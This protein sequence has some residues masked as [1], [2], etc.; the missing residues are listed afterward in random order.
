MEVLCCARRWK[1]SI[2]SQLHYE[3]RVCNNSLPPP[4]PPPSETIYLRLT[5]SLFKHILRRDSWDTIRSVPRK[6]WRH[7]LPEDGLKKFH[8]FSICLNPAERNVKVYI[9]LSRRYFVFSLIHYIYVYIY[10]NAVIEWN[11][12]DPDFRR[13]LGCDWGP[14]KWNLDSLI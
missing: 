5:H 6:T 10:K 3:E 4:H 14:S 11:N 13:Q 7:V 2:G 8:P 12:N 9:Y 1:K